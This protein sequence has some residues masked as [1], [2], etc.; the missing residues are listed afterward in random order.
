MKDYS[1]QILTI[2]QSNITVHGLH[3]SERTH[4]LELPGVSKAIGTINLLIQNEVSGLESQLVDLTE[5]LLETD[6]LLFEIKKVKLQHI[7]HS[8]PGTANRRTSRIG[9]IKNEYS[10]Q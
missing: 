3:V 4:L 1:N 10:N 6:S 5:L 2:L 7:S 8:K 9:K